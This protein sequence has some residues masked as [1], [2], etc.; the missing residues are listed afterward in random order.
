MHSRANFPHIK[1]LAWPCRKV[2]L[3]NKGVNRCEWEAGSA[4]GKACRYAALCLHSRSLDLVT[5][6]IMSACSR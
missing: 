6:E 5:P 4:S 1:A 2:M 3:F